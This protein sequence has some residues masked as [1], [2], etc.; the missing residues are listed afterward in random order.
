MKFLKRTIP[1]ILCIV[2]LLS[3][4]SKAS[5]ET[6]APTEPE[7]MPSYM[8]AAAKFSNVSNY[9]LKIHYDQTV[10]IGSDSYHQVQDQELTVE[11]AGSDDITI[12]AT[13]NVIIGDEAFS[14][15]IHLI[16]GQGYLNIGEQLFASPLAASEL[17][18]HYAP[19]VLL[20][21]G[22][23][24][25]VETEKIDNG[26]RVIFSDAL[27]IEDWL[28]TETVLLHSG[29]GIATLDDDGNLTGNHY[30]VSYTDGQS[31]VTASVD[32]EIVYN[33][34]ALEAPN[35]DLYR[36]ITYVLAPILL[37]KSCGYISTAEN[38]SSTNISQIESDAFGIQRTQSTDIQITNRTEA[39]NAQ[40]NTM[41][42]QKNANGDATTVTQSQS[43][44]NGT[45]TATSSVEDATLPNM[46]QADMDHYC[47][48]LLL[49]NIPTAKYITEASV[50][51][52]GNYSILSFHASAE[53][54]DTICK[55]ISRFL[56]G[57][58]NFIS[59]ISENIAPAAALCYLTI[60]QKTGLPTASGLS[61]ETTHTINETDFSIKY[62][63]DS[64]YQLGLPTTTEA[65]D[66]A[67]PMLYKVEDKNGNYFWLLAATEYGDH[68]TQTQTQVVYD[69]LT[70]STIVLSDFNN[71][72]VLPSDTAATDWFSGD[73][74]QQNKT[75]QILTVTGSKT[76]VVL[77]AGPAYWLHY[78]QS[79]L[80]QQEYRI[81]E[82][83]SILRSI[84]NYSAPTEKRTDILLHGKTPA[85]YYSQMPVE[86]Q[87]WCWN[88]LLAD[89]DAAEDLH[90]NR[91]C[92]L[93]SGNATAIADS[94][95][96]TYGEE[97][98][99]HTD[100]I[101]EA[102]LNICSDITSALTPYLADD[103]VAFA[104]IDV[105]YLLMDGGI[106]SQLQAQEYTITQV[107]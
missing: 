104:V 49:G 20:N 75:E 85:D 83:L 78:T 21:I 25:T 33:P 57:D 4:C 14:Y 61:F 23:Y 99:I 89:A 1:L 2:F 91:Y 50:E 92:A 98:Q 53:M 84:L 37:E 60:N 107:Q 32:V 54:T 106:L 31:N 52:T 40:L 18:D 73:L 56:Y 27:D 68:R 45:Y 29:S 19:A 10:T 11:N 62:H 69:A 96:C 44:S 30:E 35:T 72:K 22:L 66:P 94:L 71:A 17:L 42:V 63:V 88:A 105:E 58:E 64:N 39:Y 101:A 48:N 80:I 103:T 86:T 7:E 9:T 51:N 8:D 82:N 74:E 6:S 26:Y 16:D 24:A 5:V 13:E 77:N 76:D 67:K 102:T 65:Q 97:D 81:S 70:E 55:N 59:S 43:Y 95:V 28:M 3:A 79:H 15:T 36:P 12:M 100:A 34:T 41:V 38:I 90:Y 93:I 47:R 87:L 46:T